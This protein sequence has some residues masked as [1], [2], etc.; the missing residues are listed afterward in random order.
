MKKIMLAIVLL[1]LSQG[2]YNS[3]NDVIYIAKSEPIKPFK[4]LIYAI[5]MVE[6]NCDTLAY[7]PLEEAT[8]YFQI[9]PIRLNDYNK[10]TGSNYKMKDLYDYYISEEIFLYY[11]DLV[12]PNL[13]TI[14]KKWNGLGYMTVIYW[15]KVKE[16]L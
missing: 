14:S 10:R 12:G 9:R 16:Y 5:G 15:N 13:E 8:G 6:G 3:V 11:C 4:Q 2:V 7:N 1:L